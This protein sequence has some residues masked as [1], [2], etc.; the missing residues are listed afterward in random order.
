MRKTSSKTTSNL[1]FICLCT[2][3]DTNHMVPGQA[4]MRKRHAVY[5]GHHSVME[6]YKKCA[7]ET[8]ASL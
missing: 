7:G 6:D 2:G 8:Y 1:E 3:W 4:G 5:G